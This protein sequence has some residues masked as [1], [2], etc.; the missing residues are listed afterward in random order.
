M[1]EKRAPKKAGP[2]L[3]VLRHWEE[4]ADWFFARSARFPK[5]MRM[6]VTTRA[7]TMVLDLLDHLIIARYQPG[8]RAHRLEQANL[9]LERL[10]FLLRLAKKRNSWSMKS[11]EHA[12]RSVDECGRMIHGWRSGLKKKGV[13]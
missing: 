6:S 10:R 13:A 2:D 9:L 11:F 4:F 12:M 5:L 8:E 3:V 1:A 7:E